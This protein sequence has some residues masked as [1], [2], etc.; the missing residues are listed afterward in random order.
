MM[1]MSRRSFLPAG[2]MRVVVSLLVIGLALAAT[3]CGGD[4]DGADELR[5]IVRDEPL[6]VGD[7]SVTDATDGATEAE[8]TF[9]AEPGELLV[10]FFGYTNCPDICPT[11]LAE[12]RAAK[13][14]LGDAAERVDIAMVTV[15]PDR[16]VPE[17]MNGYLNSF[18]DR[19]HALRPGSEEELRT[20]ETAFLASSS[21]TTQ[22]DGRIE[23]VHSATAYVVDEHGVVVVEWPFGHG[24]EA[25]AGDL[26]VLFDR[27]GADA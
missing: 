3:G 9:R 11:T 13:R 17:V 27:M 21:V 20:A 10:V 14:L 8:F 7:V 16:D 22:P 26:E 23:V 15:D 25:M 19:F 24:S 18:S 4:D 1:A 12:V 2:A 5:G 6:V